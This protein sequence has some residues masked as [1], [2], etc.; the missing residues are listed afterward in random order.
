MVTVS[1]AADVADEGVVKVA[2]EVRVGATGL[3]ANDAVTPLGRFEA[4][5][6]SI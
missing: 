2:V 3:G 1:L 6:C 4:A 5:N